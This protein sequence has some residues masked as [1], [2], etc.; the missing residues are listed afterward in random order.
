MVSRPLRILLVEDDPSTSRA[1][2]RI[3]ELDGHSVRTASTVAAARRLAEDHGFDAVIS[4]LGLPDGSGVDLMRWLRDR[5]GLGG[6]AV[7]G[8]GPGEGGAAAREEAGFSDHL[9]KPIDLDRL[10]AALRKF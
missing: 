3:R 4:D 10:R 9:V 2:A 1:M 5:H 8:Y 6:L 7:T